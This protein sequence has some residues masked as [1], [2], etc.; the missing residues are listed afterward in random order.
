VQHK[1]TYF[2]TGLPFATGVPTGYFRD[3][4]H[5]KLR[6]VGAG[7]DPDFAMG[8]GC[9]GD[10]NGAITVVAERAALI[11]NTNNTD[12]NEVQATSVYRR[13]SAILANESEMTDLGIAD[14][15]ILACDDN[16]QQTDL[17]VLATST[18]AAQEMVESHLD[19]T[20][21][22]MTLEERQSLI[23][24]LD[25]FC[26]GFVNGPRIFEDPEALARDERRQAQNAAR[27]LREDTQKEANEL[28]ARRE[29]KAEAKE[30]EE[31]FAA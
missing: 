23:H 16:I 29:W 12:G 31:E 14:A 25:R 30:I 3:W 27:K 15:I 8:S 5:N 11:M 20:G 24:A 21:E 13:L 6:F 4:L 22:R 9:N 19:V 2:K 17:P 7:L 28:A 1:L 10:F 18:T 26:L